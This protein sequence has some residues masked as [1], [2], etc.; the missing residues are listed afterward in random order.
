MEASDIGVWVL[1]AA[2]ALYLVGAAIGVRH[3]IFAIRAEPMMDSMLDILD[4]INA[5]NS[6]KPIPVE[7]V[8]DNGRN[9]WLLAGSILLGLAGAAMLAAHVS[10]LPLLVLLVLQ[11]MLYFWRQRRRELAAPNEDQA[12]EA[13]PQ[14]STINGFFGSLLVTVLAAWLYFENA[15][16]AELR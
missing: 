10:A 1:R 8:T 14:R 13:R 15:L 12:S 4:R 5:E 11:Q 3:A 2:G 16:W 9:W 7:R 6:D